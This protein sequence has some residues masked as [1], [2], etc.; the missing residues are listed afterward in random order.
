MPGPVL[1]KASLFWNRVGNL[2]VLLSWTNVPKE[3]RF[4]GRQTTADNDQA[5]WTNSE[6]KPLE[7]FLEEG[8]VSLTLKEESG[9][10]ERHCRHL[11][12]RTG[13]CLG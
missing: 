5:E 12:G 8:A 11:I 6:G 2:Q 1:R 3:L 10:T 4:Y 7:G 13:V 9:D